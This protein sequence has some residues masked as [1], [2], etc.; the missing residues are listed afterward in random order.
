MA[1]GR[2]LGGGP[3][4]NLNAAYA[5]LRTAQKVR[6]GELLAADHGVSTAWWSTGLDGATW[7]RVRGLL[8]RGAG[9]ASGP[10]RV[11]ATGSSGAS[12]PARAPATGSSGSGLATVGRVA[13]VVVSGL[14]AV[15]LG[16]VLFSGGEG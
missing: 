7:D 2:P 5:A 11:P 12:G 3:C 14:A 15:G 4:G 10:A 16:V 13:L 9:G 8:L 1:Q 6:C